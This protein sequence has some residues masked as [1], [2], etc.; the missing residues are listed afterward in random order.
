MDGN[1]LHIF[2]M[3]G[4]KYIDVRGWTEDF[5]E[6]KADLTCGREYTKDMIEQYTDIDE[7]DLEGE[8]FAEWIIDRNR[9]YYDV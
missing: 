8:K 1:A 6:F 4:D 5:M 7:E 2:C 9:Q 3:K